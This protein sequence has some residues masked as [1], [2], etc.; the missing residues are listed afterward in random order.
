MLDT[1]CV[2][3]PPCFIGGRV[4]EAFTNAFVY[5]KV[6]EARTQIEE[7]LE[8]LCTIDGP[9]CDASAVN[10]ITCELI[11][12]K[13][14]MV[15][16]RDS[17]LYD[18]CFLVPP[19][20][21]ETPLNIVIESNSEQLSPDLE[22]V[23]HCTI[24]CSGSLHWT[25]NG[26]NLPTRAVVSNVTAFSST[27]TIVGGSEEYAGLYACLAHTPSESYDAIAAIRVEFNGQYVY[28]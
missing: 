10:N 2:C 21:S 12:G 13:F 14:T 25:F 3:I 19:L 20:P 28:C 17:Y 6:L 4:A 23:L 22:L 27:L 7:C 8:C 18:Y 11:R 15:M 26:A 16:I 9:I 1:E 5:I 24:N